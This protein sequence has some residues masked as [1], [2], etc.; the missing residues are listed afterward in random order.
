M[1]GLTHCLHG[2]HTVSSFPCSHASPL[3]NPVRGSLA[4]LRERGRL[5]GATEQGGG[6]GACPQKSGE[7]W[8]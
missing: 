8:V 6:G 4:H 7:R 3:S 2:V 5:A 1:E